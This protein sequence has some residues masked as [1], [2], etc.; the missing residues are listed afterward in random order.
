MDLLIRKVAA[1]KRVEEAMALII[2]R[3]KRKKERS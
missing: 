3:A 1:I 2:K